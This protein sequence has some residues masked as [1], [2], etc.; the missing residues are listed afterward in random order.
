MPSSLPAPPLP[1]GWPDRLA[2]AFVHATALAH[3][4]LTASRGWCVNSPIARVRLA[5]HNDLLKSEVALLREELRIKDARA[6][7]LPPARRTHYIPEERLAI[8]QLRAARGWNAA[9]TARRMLLAPKTVADWT[10]RL[11]QQGQEEFLRPKEPVNRFPDFVTALVQQLAALMPLMGRRQMADLLARAGLALSASTIARKRRSERRLSRAQFGAWRP[12]NP[13]FLDDFERHSCPE[14]RL[15]FGWKSRWTTT[16]VAQSALVVVSSAVSAA[17]RSANARPGKI[18]IACTLCYRQQ[19]ERGIFGETSDHALRMA[20]STVVRRVS[21]IA[22]GSKLR[23][24]QN[25]KCA[26]TA[27]LLA[28]IS[29]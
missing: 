6:A 27:S 4:A 12:A 28:A 19:S 15:S 9:D 22:F 25:G 26:N 23:R 7:R 21:A 13:T 16:G 14:F 17:N 8:L 2:L 5:A 1:K 20:F 3:Q 10:A 18:W 29:P 11:D 24:F